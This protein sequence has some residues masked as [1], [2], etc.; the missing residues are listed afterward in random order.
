MYRI[1]ATTEITK[2]DFKFVY[3]FCYGYLC[4]CCLEMGYIK[5]INTKNKVIEH[6]YH[7]YDDDVT[8]IYMEKKP[9][10]KIINFYDYENIKE[11]S[12]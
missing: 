7:E 3:E 4:L 12:L 8:E 5:Y 11:F 10:K 2:F 9:V 1:L 6:E